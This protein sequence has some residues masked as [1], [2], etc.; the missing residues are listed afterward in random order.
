MRI[1]KD[2]DSRED[3]IF[4]SDEHYSDKTEKTR[5]PG[6]YL[7]VFGILKLIKEIL[8]GEDV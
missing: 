7:G 4:S 3:I 2:S 6:E 1:L 5:D 8:D